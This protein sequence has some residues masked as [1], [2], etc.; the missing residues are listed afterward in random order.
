MQQKKTIRLKQVY[1]SFDKRLNKSIARA[2]QKDCI[3]KAEMLWRKGV[4]SQ[5][6]L[7]I[8]Q[9]EIMVK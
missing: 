5:D 1:I 4:I 9:D 2:E 3:S 7:P 6:I 8:Q